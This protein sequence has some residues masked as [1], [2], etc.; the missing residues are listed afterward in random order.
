MLK[1][2]RSKTRCRCA[3]LVVSVAWFAEFNALPA[4]ATDVT[5]GSDMFITR[6]EGC[7]TYELFDAALD[8]PR[9]IPAGFF[10]S[11]SL[12]FTGTIC[13]AGDPIPGASGAD[14]IVERLD[15]ATLPCAGSDTVD[16]QI[17]ALR[18][19]STEP[20]IV[21]FSG[22]GSSMYDV[23]VC[24]AENLAQPTGTMTIS[25][26]CPEGGTVHSEL[27]VIPKLT[28]TEVGPGPGLPMVV[29]DP[30][31]DDPATPAIDPLVFITDGY[32]AHA[33]T[34]GT[35]GVVSSPGGTVDGDCDGMT[36]DTFAATSNFIM[37]IRVFPCSSCAGGGTPKPEKILTEE[38]AR[39]A[40][41][42]IYPNQTGVNCCFTDDVDG[43]GF[44]E[45]INTAGPVH[46]SQEAAR[47]PGGPPGGIYLPN[48]L[49]VAFPGLPQKLGKWCVAK[50]PQP[51]P[52]RRRCP[53]AAQN[54]TQCL[55]E[56]TGACCGNIANPC[57]DDLISQSEC[58][59]V[60]NGL[61][62][63]IGVDCAAANCTTLDVGCCVL[64]P[65]ECQVTTLAHC[66]SLNGA[67]RGDGTTCDT[68]ECPTVT[69]WGMA[70]MGALVLVAGVAVAYRRKIRRA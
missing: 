65:K 38:Q 34:G 17:R 4:R 37:G 25:H 8:P 46:C 40:A 44:L 62:L 7:S 45:C 10:G 60:E 59:A 47:H 36:D 18:L 21:N 29:L 66:E 39:A 30:A 14:T 32:W 43:D 48:D 63:G 35:Y 5:P 70:A 2:I 69:Q 6:E 15:L 64:A 26:E 33:D 57:R 1:E 3:A 31:D 13:F 9:V 42:G 68:A 54:E 55:L 20:I 52:R 58:S 24:L 22:G 28:F 50:Q 53:Q 51:P 61:F 27:P 67:Y 56:Q 12:P 23:E 49:C 41:H 11:G 19:I 16:I